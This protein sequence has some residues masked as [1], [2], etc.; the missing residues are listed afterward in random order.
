[1][2]K[3]WIVF[4][5]LAVVIGGGFGLLWYHVVQPGEDASPSTAACWSGRWAATIPRN[6]TT[7]S[8][9]RSA[10]AAN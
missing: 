6:G 1:M 4:I 8:G 3:F 9:A 10:A 7:P 5:V 2:K